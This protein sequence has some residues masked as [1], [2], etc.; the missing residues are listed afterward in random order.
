L[1]LNASNTALQLKEY[2]LCVDK[3]TEAIKLNPEHPKAYYYRGTAFTELLDFESAGSDFNKLESLLPEKDKSLAK[4]CLERLN[5]KVKQIEKKQRGLYKNIFKG[6][7]L[8]DDKDT[9]KKLSL[10][11][12]PDPENTFCFFD[13]AIGDN[14]PKRI[15]FELFSKVVPKTAKNFATLCLGTQKDSSGTLLSYKGSTFHRV[16]KDFMIQGGDFTQHD[17]TG[18]KSIYGNRFDDENFTYT[19]D[20]P[21]LLSSANAGPNT[22]GS[23]FFITTQKTPHL[24]GK[25]VVFGRVIEGQDFVNEIENVEKGKA[26]K[27]KIDVTIVDCGVLDKNIKSQ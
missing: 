27:P 24:D 16:I 8:Y 20:E 3:S 23:Q 21:F 4:G 7:D 26:D 12:K 25:H 5:E 6:A 10:S 17:G 18:G 15:E 2:Q 14:E 9:P 13:I 11:S 22:N 19:H 1:L